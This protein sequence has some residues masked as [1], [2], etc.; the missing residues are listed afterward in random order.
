MTLK[1]IFAFLA[2]A[3]WERRSRARERRAL[4]LEL[5][6][7][8]GLR[9]YCQEREPVIMERLAVLQKIDSESELS[10]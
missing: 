7:I 2:P 9:L 6:G 8:D 5:A 10:C 4:S 3:A 1:A